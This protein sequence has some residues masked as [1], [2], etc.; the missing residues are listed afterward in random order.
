MKIVFLD[1]SISE[2]DIMKAEFTQS[3][4][5]R[6]ENDAQTLRFLP[7]LVYVAPPQTVF[8]AKLARPFVVDGHTYTSSNHIHLLGIDSSGVLKDIVHV[9]VNTF[10]K[11][12]FEQEEVVVTVSNGKQSFPNKEQFKRTFIDGSL[13]LKVVGSDV[14]MPYALAFKITKVLGYTVGLE[15]KG[16]NWFFKTR[17][18]GNITI[19]DS[20][21]SR[22]ILYNEVDAPDYTTEDLPAHVKKLLL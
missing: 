11:T 6:I 13:P 22:L 8:G 19:L 14:V 17:K 20:K 12:Y 5:T 16:G 21:Q 7:N 18:S 15:Q 3:Q 9:P 2:G 1:R 10:S 4:L